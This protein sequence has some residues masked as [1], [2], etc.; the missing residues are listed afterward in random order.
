M[1]PT[2]G[3][4]LTVAELRAALADHHPEAVVRLR[5]TAVDTQFLRNAA[6]AVERKA[7]AAADL[8]VVVEPKFGPLAALRL[9]Y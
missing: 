8:R 7:M 6:E 5:L 2:P 3:K 4:H 1:Y 9:N